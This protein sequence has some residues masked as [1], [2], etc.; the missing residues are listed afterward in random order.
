[1]EITT[2]G[3]EPT[4][5]TDSGQSSGRISSWPI[6]RAAVNTVRRGQGETVIAMQRP[7]DTLV[8]W[9]TRRHDE[10]KPDINN[11]PFTHLEPGTPTYVQLRDKERIFAWSLDGT[12]T[13]ITWW[14]AGAQPAFEQPG[15]LTGIKSRQVPAKSEKRFQMWRTQGGQCALCRRVWPEYLITEMSVDH[16]VPRAK[17]GD[18]S[19]SN[20]QLT[21]PTCNA[22][23]KDMDN[24]DAKVLLQAAVHMPDSVRAQAV[25][26]FREGLARKSERSEAD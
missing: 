2:V 3:P 16:I 26:K 10:G 13:Q 23:K 25:R 20:L 11:P 19:D 7:W 5:V 21:C 14:K 8:F 24:D 17:G 22:S 1:M 15:F 9:T 18:D 4:L 6:V 12:E